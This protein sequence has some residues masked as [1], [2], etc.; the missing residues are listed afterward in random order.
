MLFKPVAEPHN[1]LFIFFPVYEGGSQLTP[2][3]MA[4][5][6]SCHSAETFNTVYCFR[7]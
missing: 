2:T 5:K 4:T 3:I 7:T 6:S 1:E